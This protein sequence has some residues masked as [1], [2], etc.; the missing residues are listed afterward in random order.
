MCWVNGNDPEWRAEFDRA[1]GSQTEGGVRKDENIMPVDTGDERFRDWGFL[2]YWFRGV[3]KFMPWVRDVYF[4]TWGHLPDFLDPDADRLKIVRHEEYI[5]EKY[6]P[7][8]N[9]NVIELNYHRIDGLSERFVYFND[10]M[11]ILAPTRRE[12]FFIGGQP[13][14]MLSFQP[15]VA[16]ESDDIMPY[17]YLNNMMLLA[18]HFDKRK[19]VKKHPGDY[20]HPGYPL[21]RLAYNALEMA[22]PRYT[23]LYTVHGPSPLVKST[24][25][26]LWETD[27]DKLDEC[28]MNKLR[29]RGDVNQYVIR[30]YRKLTGRFVPENLS[31]KFAYFNIGDDNSEALRVIGGRKRKVVCLNDSPHIT[32]FE[33][34][35]KKFIR[36][37]ETVLP[38]KSSF[39]K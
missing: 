30:E 39:E 15:D 9:S 6:L 16:N 1:T 36:A 14:D 18:R 5:P 32:D 13:V 11:L 2:K 25:K 17:I 21:S 26:H 28:C 7:T 38:E 4:V 22:F 10:D 31:R 20:F 24:M 37:L 27:G 33:G 8:F 23:G 35:K 19:C 29:S 3:E 12:D 34:E